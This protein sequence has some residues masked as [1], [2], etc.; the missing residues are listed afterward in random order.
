MNYKYLI[1]NYLKN[2]NFKIIA[3]ITIII[4]VIITLTPII[5]NEYALRPYISFDL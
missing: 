3:I 5:N 2:C 1:G 4:A